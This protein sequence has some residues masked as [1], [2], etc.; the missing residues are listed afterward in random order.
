VGQRET[1]IDGKRLA[2]QVT[3]FL[4][5]PCLLVGRRLMRTV[6][7]DAPAREVLPRLVSVAG[8]D[9]PGHDVAIKPTRPGAK[10]TGQD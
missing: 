10:G 9:P 3:G 8:E 6:R 4:Q 1:K 5:P 2:T 7:L